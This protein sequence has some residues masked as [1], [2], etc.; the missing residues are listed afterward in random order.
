LKKGK[1]N[2]TIS[3]V[4]YQRNDAYTAY[5]G[6]G[7]PAQLSRAQVS[8]L[9]AQASGKPTQEKTI[10]VAKDGQFELALPMRENDVYLVELDTHK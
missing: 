3:Q 6:M 9:K 2:L 4:G 1:Y 5:I 8:E 10:R 7:S